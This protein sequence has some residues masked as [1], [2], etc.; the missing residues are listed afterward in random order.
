METNKQ[1]EELL[2]VLSLSGMLENGAR[3]LGC[4][5]RQESLMALNDIPPW[6]GLTIE[7]KWLKESS[8]T[9]M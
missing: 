2:K 6:N 7:S 3:S 4:D 5:E 9:N 1:E 8:K